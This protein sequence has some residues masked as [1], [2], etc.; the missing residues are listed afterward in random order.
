M[1][2]EK[3]DRLD[4]AKAGDISAIAAIV[5]QHL[6]AR[7][8]STQ[9]SLYQKIIRIV[10]ESND[11]LDG[12]SLGAYLHRELNHLL[13][14]AVQGAALYKQRS[15]DKK[16]LL[17]HRME[18]T[19]VEPEEPAIAADE[20]DDIEAENSQPAASVESSPADDQSQP[21]I[22]NATPPPV[23]SRPTSASGAQ[24]VNAP[25]TTGHSLPSLN[26]AL[27]LPLNQLTNVDLRTNSTLRLLLFFGLTPWLLGISIRYA[28]LESVAWLLGIY[29]ACIWG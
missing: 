1:A 14:D 16:P 13:S 10:I 29:Y 23:P 27:L 6:A 5:N 9:V 19:P 22:T 17:I 12:S 18:F 11:F 20:P 28:K 4:S 26:L 8:L 15:W 2:E 7:N 3:P 25:S 21:V 24:A